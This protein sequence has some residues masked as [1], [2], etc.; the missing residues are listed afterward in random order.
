MSAPIEKSRAS[1]FFPRVKPNSFRHQEQTP[2]TNP[3]EDSHVAI[4]F[5]IGITVCEPKR[6]F[7]SN[8]L[9]RNTFDILLKQYF[10]NKSKKE[11]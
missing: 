8:Q 6:I 11:G 1:C 7:G 9:N 10:F 3:M 2:E 4:I 5:T